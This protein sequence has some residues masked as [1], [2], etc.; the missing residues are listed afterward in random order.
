[1]LDIIGCRLEE[2]FIEHVSPL[3]PER[4][5][6]LFPAGIVLSGGVANMPGIDSLLSDIFKMPVRVADPQ[7]YYQMPPGRMDAGYVN[8]AGTIRYILS[9]ERSPYSFID[10]PKTLWDTGDVS[11]PQ[12]E[13]PPM[14]KK[15]SMA[16]VRNIMEKIKESF[17]DLF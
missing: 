11:P 8:A 5:P 16:N 15:V 13:T 17:K 14:R 4:N 6:N 7:E 1:M 9:K 10:A 2:L 3:I 12:R